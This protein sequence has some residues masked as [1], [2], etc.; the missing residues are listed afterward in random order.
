MTSQPTVGIIGLGYGRA[1]IPA[2]Q[3]HGCPVVAVSQ[4]GTSTSTIDAAVASRTSAVDAAV[5]TY[6]KGLEA[7][8]A[9]CEL[10]CHNC[11]AFRTWVERAHDPTVRRA[12]INELP[13]MELMTQA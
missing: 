6:R 13:L 3:A 8:I 12:T 9:K 4:R 10:V 7:E 5:G 1:H 2:F 11:H